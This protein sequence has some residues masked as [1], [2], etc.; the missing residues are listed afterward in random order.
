MKFAALRHK[1]TPEFASIQSFNETGK[2][3]LYTHELPDPRPEDVTIEM[4][5]G[6]YDQ[7]GLVIEDG[8]FDDL[9][10]KRY[11]YFEEGVLGAD[12]R[13]KLSPIKNLLTLLTIYKD[14]KHAMDW[15]HKEY[16]EKQIIDLIEECK[17]S[18]VYISELI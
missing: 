14:Q 18:V 11:D 3:R 6:Y 1:K 12:I 13:N 17:E 10:F 15:D 5:K 4:L 8:N 7:H 16:F 2:Y 9:E